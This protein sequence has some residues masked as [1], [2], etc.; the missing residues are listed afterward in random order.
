[1]LGTWTEAQA[2]LGGHPDP[3]HGDSPPSLA[4]GKVSPPSCAQPR[5]RSCPSSDGRMTSVPKGTYQKLQ[6]RSR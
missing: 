3:G 1:M 4:R 6:G 2:Q 5:L